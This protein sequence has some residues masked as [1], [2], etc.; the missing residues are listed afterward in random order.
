MM[1]SPLE[2]QQTVHSTLLKSVEGFGLRPRECFVCSQISD[3]IR[4]MS[5]K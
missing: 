3:N 4:G 2:D 5:G 1:G